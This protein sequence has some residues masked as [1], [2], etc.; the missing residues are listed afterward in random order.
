MS[1]SGFRLAQQRAVTDDGADR[2]PRHRHDA[3]DDRIGFRMDRG[4]VERIFA[5]ADAHEARRL[6]ETPWDPDAARSAILSA[7]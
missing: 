1:S 4:T 5:V 2:A 6:F 7:I 3:A